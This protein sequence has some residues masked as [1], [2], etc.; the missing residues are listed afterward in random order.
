M[1]KYDSYDVA[2]LE[3]SGILDDYKAACGQNTNKLRYR[4][5]NYLGDYALNI[6]ECRKALNFQLIGMPTVTDAIIKRKFVDAFE[7]NRDYIVRPDIDLDKCVKDGV[8]SD[9]AKKYIEEIDSYDGYA[10]W[11]T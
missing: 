7:L 8:I 6:Y 2:M 5:L 11:H 10:N 1:Y 9:N 3:E 4:Y